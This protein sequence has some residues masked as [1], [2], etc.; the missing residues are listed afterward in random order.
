M[1]CGEKEVPLKGITGT[2]RRVETRSMVTVDHSGD[3]IFFVFGMGGR[4]KVMHVLGTPPWGPG[5]GEH[6]YDFYDQD[7][8]RD[9]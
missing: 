6:T 2:W 1:Q 5:E 3:R 7:Y 9:T 8:F 4:M